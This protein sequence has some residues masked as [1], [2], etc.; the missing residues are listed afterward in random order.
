MDNPDRFA[1]TAISDAQGEGF[2]A[3]S[4]ERQGW[5]VLYRALTPYELSQ[6]LDTLEAQEAT[7]FISAD[8]A[9]DVSHNSKNLKP[10]INVIRLNEIPTNDH[11]FSE[12]IR[13]STK[14]MGHPWSIFPS[15]PIIA[16]TSFGR[17]VGTSTIALNVASELAAQGSRVLLVDAHLRSPFLSRHLRIFGVNRDV[18]RSPLGFSIFEA[19]RAE[20]FAKIEAEIAEYEFLFIDLGEI[21]QPESAISGYRIE[22]YPFTW[23]AHYATDLISVSSEQGASLQEV[24]DSLK[25]LAE[26]ALKARISHLFNFSQIYSP[27]ELKIQQIRVEDELHCRTTFLPRDDRAA[28][29][30]KAA[31]SNLVQ[32]APK[33]ALRAEIA[34]YCRE[35]KWVL[36]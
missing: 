19:H 34:R 8:F 9:S 17:T 13:G 4:L 29:R 7:L 36:S 12:I 32:S 35:S 1:I 22:D 5:Q 31:S 25:M 15:I 2:V 10:I 30:A 18:M 24:R 23:A 16:F 28:E 26:L 20:D 6:F 33:S 3:A 11:D 27:K 14:E 21:W